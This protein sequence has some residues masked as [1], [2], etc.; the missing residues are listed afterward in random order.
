LHL[1]AANLPKS[2]KDND[3]VE[4]ED[5]VIVARASRRSIARPTCGPDVPGARAFVRVSLPRSG[6]GENGSPPMLMDV[7]R[8]NETQEKQIKKPA[9]SPRR[10]RGWPCVLEIAVIGNLIPGEE[11][12]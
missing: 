12:V 7:R 3:C 4:C 5:I 9:D 6:K 2:S 8:A 1:D 10:S 11:E